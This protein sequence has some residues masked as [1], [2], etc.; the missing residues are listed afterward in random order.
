MER[1]RTYPVPVAEA[2][3]QLLPM[4]L[5]DLFTS[6]YGPIP[7]IR[8]TIQNGVWGTAGQQRTVVFA[9]PG[10]VQEHLVAIDRPHEF[11]YELSRPTGPMA[12]LITRVHGTWAFSPVNAGT[13]ITWAWEVEA[14]N[15]MAQAV[16]PVFARLWNGYARAAFDRLERLLLD[17]P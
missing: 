15:R 11:R 8:T 1:S 5:S 7:R 13:R 17:T 6:W 2:F 4:P 9:G 16:M 3:D 12:L 10:S 14:R